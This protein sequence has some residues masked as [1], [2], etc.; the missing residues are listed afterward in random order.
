[1]AWKQLIYNGFEEPLIFT[2]SLNLG[3]IATPGGTNSNNYNFSVASNGDFTVDKLFPKY[4]ASS[5]L[6]S[7]DKTWGTLYG[8]SSWINVNNYT[9][10]TP[11][12][13]FTILSY[14]Y[15]NGRCSVYNTP[16]TYN[17]ASTVLSLSGSFYASGTI[18]AA[19]SR[20]LKENI[21]YY[22]DSALD[23]INST[24]VVSFNYKND[25]QK[26]YKVGFI[27]E[28]TDPILST[29]EK[30]KIDINNCI[31]MLIKSIQELSNK[32]SLL[33]AQNELLTN[34]LISNGMIN[35]EE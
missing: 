28:D 23:V 21:K 14:R 22:K 6:G 35:V 16:L 7:S 33:E 27:A 9:N 2:N 10:S 29:K 3:Y 11:D 31:G 13:S 4:N 1:M 20:K 12:N 19:S 15:D 34:K 8:S 17:K 24:E 26:A 5:S 25:E 18:T 30:D 32:V